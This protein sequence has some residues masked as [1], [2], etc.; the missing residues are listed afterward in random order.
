MQSCTQNGREGRFA[1]V[2]QP[3]VSDIRKALVT[4]L[5]AAYMRV[6]IIKYPD[7]VKPD[8]SSLVDVGITHA[9]C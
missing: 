6:I 9:L 3:V 8:C 1:R 4:A 5:K 2:K 7:G